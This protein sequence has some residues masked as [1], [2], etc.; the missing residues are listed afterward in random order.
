MSGK[1][2]I[3]ILDSEGNLKSE[4]IDHNIITE[5]GDAYIADLLSLIPTRTKFSPT[6]CFISVGTGWTGINTKQNSWVN[7]QVGVSHIIDATYP[8]LKG[9]WG[10]AGDSVLQFQV[11]FEAGTL[12]FN[13]IN[14]AALTTHATDTADNS[15]V[16]YAQV[17]PPVNVTSSDVLIISW[18]LSFL[19]A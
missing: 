19:G 15:T 17:T 16:A 4:S 6:N 8:K 18:E 7:T 13:G 2:K 1:V 9:A 12:N 3:Q 11:T 14:E 10:T 5:E